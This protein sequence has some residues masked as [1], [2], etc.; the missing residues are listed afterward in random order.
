MITT[1]HTAGEMRGDREVVVGLQD[2]DEQA[3]E[4]EQQDHRE[5]HLREP[6]R[7]RR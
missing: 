7:Q 1:F 5:Q 4:P 2:P 3:V 6:D